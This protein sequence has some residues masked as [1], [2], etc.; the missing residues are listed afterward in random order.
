M[1]RQ[2]ARQTYSLSFF[3]CRQFIHS[4]GPFLLSHLVTG[5]RGLHDDNDRV[6]G[7]LL[8]PKNL[9]HV[10]G[11]VLDQGK[12]FSLKAILAKP[13][14]SVNLLLQEGQPKEINKNG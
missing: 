14:G 10:V 7:A 4:K 2:T 5:V 13:L 12:A 8:G 3:K 1:V 11:L 6:V 9:I